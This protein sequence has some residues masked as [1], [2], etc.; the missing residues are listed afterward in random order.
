M[1]PKERRTAIVEFVRW[2]WQEHGIGPTIR[3]LAA[4]FGV[5]P[6]VMQYDVRRLVNQGRLE[7]RPEGWSR[8]LRAVDT[9]TGG[10]DHEHQ[11]HDGTATT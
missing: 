3:E 11:L 9:D 1:T 2:H 4:Q 6:S 5:S 10:S 8:A 7:R